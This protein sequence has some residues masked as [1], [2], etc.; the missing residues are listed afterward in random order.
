[1]RSPLNGV[2]HKTLYF[3]RE[4]LATSQTEKFE[5]TE[6]NHHEPNFSGYDA[7]EIGVCFH[8]NSIT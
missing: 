5:V 6:E 4:D 8:I 7:E 2:D 1:M 3:Y